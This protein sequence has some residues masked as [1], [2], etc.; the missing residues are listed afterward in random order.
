M[1]NAIL[2]IGHSKHSAQDFLALLA[3]HDIEA[4]ADV[5]SS[6]FSRFCPQFNRDALQQ[7]LAG[8][9]VKYVFLGEALGGRP[10]DQDCYEGGQVNYRKV[11]QS[12]S[13]L[14]GLNR[15]L[16]GAQRY[17]IACMCSEK[18]PLNCHRTLLIGEALRERQIQMVHILGDGRL[19]TQQGAL[20]RLLPGQGQGSLFASAGL[21]SEPSE[22]ILRDAVDAQSRKAAYSR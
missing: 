10:A 7:S 9:G 18:E 21:V 11:A 22:K 1:I 12:R 17:R 15:L 20:M 14:N 5:R 2:S 19:E 13:F 16:Q 8:R 6:P 3:A 4:L